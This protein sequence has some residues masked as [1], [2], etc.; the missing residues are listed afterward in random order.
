[1]QPRSSNQTPQK[2]KT[3]GHSR[4][5]WK[6]QFMRIQPLRRID[7]VPSSRALGEKVLYWNLAW[8]IL[9]LTEK[10]AYEMRSPLQ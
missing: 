7:G 8:K 2:E 1:M 4:I 10:R 9:C 3:V 5:G 6:M